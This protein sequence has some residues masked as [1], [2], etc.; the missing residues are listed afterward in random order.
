M[1]T[2]TRDLGCENRDTVRLS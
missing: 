1:I 2:E